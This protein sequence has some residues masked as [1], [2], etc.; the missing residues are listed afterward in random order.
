MAVTDI[1]NADIGGIAGQVVFWVVI[2][3]FMVVLVGVLGFFALWVF[4]TLKFKVR[5]TIYEHV[6]QNNHVGKK[7]VGREVEK[8]D[9]G[10]RV[11][12]IRLLKARKSIG[13]FGSDKFVVFGNNKQLN[14]H[15]EDGIFTPLPI[16]HNSDPSFNFEKS[17]LLTALQLWDQDYAENLE[18][19]KWGEP[20]FMDKYGNFVMPFAMILIMFVLFFILIQQIG[21]GVHVT[22]SIDTS[23]LVKAAA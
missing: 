3:I 11:R 16:A 18:T 2:I 8:T 9:G 21:G 1:A 19:H 20:S 14:L 15:L 10:K 22:A 4:R 23:Q 7:D 6:G 13:P 5:V 12:F 17:D